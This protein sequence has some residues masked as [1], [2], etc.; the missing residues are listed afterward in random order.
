MPA[1]NIRIVLVRPQGA[2]N[3]GGVAR[4]MKNMGLS[5]LALVRPRFRK[6]ALARSMAVHAADVLENARTYD[7]LAAAV[8]DCG[9]VAGTTCRLGPYRNAPLT[10]RQAAV[11][12]SRASGENKVALVFGPEDHGLSN[13]DIQLLHMLVTI[14]TD[15]SYASLN[16]AQAVGICC[17]EIFAASNDGVSRNPAL[18]LSTSADT[19]LMFERLQ[20]ALTTIGFLNRDNP[21]HIMY[22]LRSILGRARLDEREVRILLGLARQIEWYGGTVE[23]VEDKRS[24][25][26][27]TPNP[28]P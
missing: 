13:R 11:E 8:A 17:Y 19:E 21:E 14:P 28:E 5:D 7:T 9:L 3:T 4:V 12:L 1:A 18:A 23:K 26:P 16:L 22:A 6:H 25:E 20:R 24:G 2:A 15:D 10:P 27:R